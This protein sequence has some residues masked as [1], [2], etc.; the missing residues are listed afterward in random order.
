MQ[1]DPPVDR[2]RLDQILDGLGLGPAGPDLVPLSAGRSGAPSYLIQS[3]P[4]RLVLRIQPATHGRERLL[5]MAELQRLAATRD[6]AP[7][8]LHVDPDR[9][10]L[11]SAHV[12]G[13]PLS[14]VL[15]Q[16]DPAALLTLMG[17]RVGELH[18]LSASPERDPRDPTTLTRETF[19]STA[20]RYELPSVAKKAWARFANHAPSVAGAPVLCHHD[21]NPTNILVDGDT[22]RFVDWETAGIGDGTFDLATLIDLLLLTPALTERLL[23]GYDETAPAGRPSDEA[24]LDARRLA[25]LAYGIT[26]L[27]LVQTP[28]PSETEVPT[29][30]ECYQ[31]MGRGEL[32]SSVDSGRWRIGC[33]LLDEYLRIL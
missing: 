26:F 21:L 32:D 16:R 22:V 14:E 17:R 29:L 8:V 6:L 18:A 27:G 9:R 30:A 2:A 10:W 25:Y 31:Q 1:H 33:A 20:K 11:L 24:L 19:E 5:R 12:E 23:R 7:D 13:R 15:T 28:Q 3:G 4:Q